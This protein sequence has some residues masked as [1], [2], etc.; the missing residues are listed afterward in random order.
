VL[1]KK[2]CDDI[3]YADY[4]G[5]LQA[6]RAEFGDD[7]DLLQMSAFLLDYPVRAMESADTVIDPP[8]WISS[9]SAN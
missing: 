1:F 7:P 5:S 8:T 9:A 3:G 2:L 4:L 6:F